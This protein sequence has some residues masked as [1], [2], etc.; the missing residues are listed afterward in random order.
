[1]NNRDE[2]TT[3]V[4]NH[5]STVVCRVFLEILLSRLCFRISFQTLKIL[6]LVPSFCI[7][8]VRFL[9][10]I[11]ELFVGEQIKQGGI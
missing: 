11:S 10:W 5:Q 8:E 7:F 9:D 2:K 1:M 6:E 4:L 3:T